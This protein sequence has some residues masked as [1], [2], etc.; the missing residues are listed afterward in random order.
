M[1]IRRFADRGYSATTMDEI[2]ESAGVTKPLLYHH[3][4][5]KRAL[6]LELVEEVSRDLLESVEKAT[7]AAS[8]PRELVHASFS[9]YF[10]HVAR[11][12]DAF[13]LLFGS[14]EP[15]DPELSRALRQVEE[16]V[17]EA[18]SPLIDADLEV[19]HRALLAHAIVGS[20]VSSSRYWLESHGS[21]GDA[22]DLDEAE[23]TARRVADLAWAGL[24]AVHRD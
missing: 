7:A 20:A 22:L 12:Q 16:R 3:F 24:R 19:S 1:A 6:Y 17:A 11:R 21:G 23:R 4:G 18:V 13:R 10:R 5:S 2:A 15:N 9:A 14:D 8:G